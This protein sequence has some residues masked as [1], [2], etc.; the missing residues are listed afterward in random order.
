MTTQQEQEYLKAHPM[1]V[2]QQAGSDTL[3]QS[4]WGARTLTDC[5]RMEVHQKTYNSR[6]KPVPRVR[7]P[8]SWE[9]G[10]ANER[11]IAQHG[12]GLFSPEFL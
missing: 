7:I 10:M 8:I 12:C 1:R 2:L 11:C 5:L 3:Y 6:P 4:K 9:L